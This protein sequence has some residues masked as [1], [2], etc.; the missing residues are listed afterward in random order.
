MIRTEKYFKTLF[1]TKIK[2]NFIS[3][4]CQC[5]TATYVTSFDSRSRDQFIRN[6]ATYYEMTSHTFWHTDISSA[7]S[8]SIA[9]LFSSYTL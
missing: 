3:D 4:R 8:L 2:H 7:L 5:D 6:R 9:I 1:E